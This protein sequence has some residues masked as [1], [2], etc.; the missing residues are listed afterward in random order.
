MNLNFGFYDGELLKELLA[1]FS[2]TNAWTTY[3]VQG[4]FKDEVAYSNAVPDVFSYS[5]EN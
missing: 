2:V 1:T 3:K 5:N 4:F